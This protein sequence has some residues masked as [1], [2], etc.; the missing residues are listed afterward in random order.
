MP[1]I[2]I[3]AAHKSSGKT[4]VSLGIGAAL[5]QRGHSVQPFKKGPDYIDP[6]WLQAATG[7]PC[8]NLDFNTQTHDEIKDCFA[9]HLGDSQLALIEGNKGLYD[10]MDRD[11][12]DCNAAMAKLLDAPVILVL[13]SHGITRNA[14]PLLLGLQQFDKEVNIAGVI[15]NKTAGGRHESKLKAVIEH[16]TDIP[17]LGAIQRHSDLHIDERHLGLMPSNETSE[18]NRIIERIANRVAQSVDLDAILRIAE[19]TVIAPL[20]TDNDKPK[21]EPFRLGIARDAAF[22][23]YYPDDIEAFK[24]SGAEIVTFD[25]LKDDK[26][27]VI[28][29]LFIGGGFPETQLEAL[30]ANNSMLDSIKTAIDSGMPA[31]AEC[32]GLMYLTRSIQW[33]DKKLDM[34]GVIPADSLMHDHAIG[35]GY[36]L[37]SPTRDH[38]WNMLEFAPQTPIHAHEFHYSSLENIAAESSYAYEVSR[39]AGISNNMDGICHNNLI[40]TYIHQRQT[41]QNLWVDAFCSFIQQQLQTTNTH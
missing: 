13:D 7:R 40:A 3:S 25:T 5:K 14:A 29:A 21:G 11:G 8:F 10:G 26:L 4:T 33:G 36:T 37:Y 35:R 28:D 41:K 17:I 1:H 32:G 20:K 19:Q 24:N 30:H 27:P 6:I 31:Y 9:S 38:P 39:G 16:Y 15:L 2:Y 18:A 34:A 22:G 12:S 23:F